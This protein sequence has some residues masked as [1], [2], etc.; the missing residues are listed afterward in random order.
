MIL[1]KKMRHATMVSP[2]TYDQILRVIQKFEILRRDLHSFDEDLRMQK[3]IADMKRKLA[4][5]AVCE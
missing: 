3:M 4:R 1:Y 2:T 5:A